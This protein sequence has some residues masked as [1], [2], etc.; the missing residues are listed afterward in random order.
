MIYKLSQLNQKMAYKDAVKYEGLIK[1]FHL[2]QLKLL[3]SE[4][5]FMTKYA[6]P[7]NKILYVGAAEGYHIAKLADMFPHNIFDLWDPSPFKVDKRNNITIYNKFFTNKEA[8][9]YKDAG[10]NILFICDIRTLEIGDYKK[11]HDLKKMDEI[12]I[13]DMNMQMGWLKIINPIY[14]Y[15]KYRV[16]YV[17]PTMEYLT[18]TIYLQPYSPFSTETRLLTSN[19]TKMKTYNNQDNEE[20]MAYFNAKIRSDVKYKKWEDIMYEYKIK[21]NWDNN[22][23]FY[24]LDYYLRTINNE[25]SKKEVADLFMDIINFHKKKYGK[26]YDVVFEINN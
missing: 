5:L 4:I 15:L 20:K 14:A 21:N 12:V 23:A 8:T 7:N 3:F 9:K 25:S 19:Y 16:P 17:V 22:Y 1:D 26:K 24:I 11:V 18:G 10:N 13:D 2:G 6:K